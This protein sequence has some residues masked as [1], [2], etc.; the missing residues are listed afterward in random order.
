[1]QSAQKIPGYTGHIP[2]RIDIVGHTTGESNRQ[3]GDNFRFAA[4]QGM[5]DT[6]SSIIRQQQIAT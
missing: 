6:G 2:F 5:V 4:N 3:A 1:M